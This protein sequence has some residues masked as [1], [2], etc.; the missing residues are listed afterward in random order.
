MLADSWSLSSD[1]LTYTFKLHPGVKFSDGT[2]FDSAAVKAAFDRFKTLGKGA[3]LLFDA[4]DK[5]NTVDATTV[6][7][8]LKF[9]LAVPDGPRLVAGGDL[10][11]SHR[12][13]G[14]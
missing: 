8:V 3:V 10:R 13:E 5:I 11:Q 4:I 6:A 7:F 9:L 2:P 12:R 1:G 14:E